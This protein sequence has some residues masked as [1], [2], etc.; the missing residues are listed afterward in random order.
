ME[1]EGIFGEFEVS[2]KKST[3]M[4]GMTGPY[5]LMPGRM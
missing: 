4:G 5:T 3:G 1:T 2:T